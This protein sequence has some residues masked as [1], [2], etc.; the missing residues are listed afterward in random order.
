MF[1]FI[2]TSCS[3][4]QP[5]LTGG[6]QDPA[7]QGK[8]D[9]M[10][11]PARAA[12]ESGLASYIGPLAPYAAGL[13]I[14]ILYA[15][16]ILKRRELEAAVNTHSEILDEAKASAPEAVMNAYSAVLAKKPVKT[17]NTIEKAYRKR[18]GRA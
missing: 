10:E 17:Q 8:P 4:L 7:L 18:K 12:I 16:G 15:L 2:F 9:L 14:T 11:A 6:S 3:L 5:L 13:I 1:V